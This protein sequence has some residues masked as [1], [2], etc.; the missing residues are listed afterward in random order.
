MGV[1][2]NQEQIDQL[3][4]RVIYKHP[5]ADSLS[6]KR[7]PKKTAEIFKDFA[8]KEFVGDYGMALKYLVDKVLIEPQ[9]FAQIMT[10]VEDHEARLAR[11]ENKVTVIKTIDGTKRYIEKK[12]GEENGHK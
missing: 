1:E 6:M 12:G 3:K 11:I 2:E 5:E 10:L 4:E 8:N 9:A 7:I